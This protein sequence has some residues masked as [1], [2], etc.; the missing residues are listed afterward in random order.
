MAANTN[1]NVVASIISVEDTLL[2]TKTYQLKLAGMDYSISGVS[3]AKLGLTVDTFK[4]PESNIVTQTF[5]TNC[6]WVRAVI[7]PTSGTI[8]KV[9]LRN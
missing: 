3:V 2:N 5:Q 7:K 9:L 8:S 6:N 1:A 4:K